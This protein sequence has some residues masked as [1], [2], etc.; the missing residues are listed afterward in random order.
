MG[1]RLEQ[2]QGRNKVV[3]KELQSVRKEVNDFDVTNSLNIFALVLT[4]Q[5]ISETLAVIC[6]K[7]ENHNKE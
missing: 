3:E 4:L 7:M 6:D 1:K 2:I 5:D